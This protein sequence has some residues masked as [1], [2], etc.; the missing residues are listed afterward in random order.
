[1]L[2]DAGMADLINNSIP[3]GVQYVRPGVS[4][5]FFNENYFK[6]WLNVSIVNPAITF[7]AY[8]KCLSYWI[9]NHKSIP[10]NFRLVASKGGKLDRLI[11]QYRLPYAEIVF[12]TEEARRKGL[13]IDHD[14]SHA[15]KA[16]KPFALLLHGCQ[17]AGTIASKVWEI[18]RNTI[19]GYGPKNYWNDPISKPIKL[20]VT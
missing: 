5:D 1:L 13:E 4:G 9:K 10:P 6:A 11:E 16:N 3:F 18:I 19:G 7:Y 20:V 15:I 2:Q 8:T 12:S 17:P 14:D